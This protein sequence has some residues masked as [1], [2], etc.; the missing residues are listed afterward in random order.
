MN[1]DELE[2]LVKIYMKKSVQ[3]ALIYRQK[4]ILGKE[5]MQMQTLLP[6]LTV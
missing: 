5:I 6:I 4:M 3:I 2:N 1:S